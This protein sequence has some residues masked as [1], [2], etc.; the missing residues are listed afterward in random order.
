MRHWAGVL[1]TAIMCSLI[2]HDGARAQSLPS[3]AC[4]GASAPVERVICSD[5][6][7][8]E[9]DH[10]M[11]IAYFSLLNRLQNEQHDVL[12]A[13]QRN[14]LEF[15]VEECGLSK[16][17]DV[18]VD[19][20]LRARSC[21][22]RLYNDRIASLLSDIP[23]SV[24]SFKC[25]QS[26]APIEQII[27]SDDEI[28]ELD[29]RM[30]SLYSALES[31]LQGEQ[32]AALL[33]E[34]R[35]W[36]DSR[37]TQCGVPASGTIAVEAAFH[38]RDCLIGTYK[39]RIEKLETTDHPLSVDV[40]NDRPT[41]ITAQSAYFTVVAS[42][43][44][45]VAA[46]RQL[47]H[48]M[49]QYPFERFS[50]YPPYTNT[51]S[52]LVVV[53][54]Y[55]DET[56]ANDARNEVRKLGIA[57]NPVVW[58]IPAPFQ[59][60]DGWT[61]Q[62]IQN[63]VLDCLAS[64]A[65][66][67]EAM[68]GCSG[69]VLTPALLQTCIKD[70]AC[71]LDLDPVAAADVLQSQ[72]LT[73]SSPLTIDPSQALP[74]P[75]TLN[76]L[77]TCMTA[78]PDDEAG[79]TACAQNV[80]IGSLPVASCGAKSGDGKAFANCVLQAAGIAV[81]QLDCLVKG[82]G[83]RS[84]CLNVAKLPQ[85]TAA[86][87]CLS[88]YK[89][90][91]VDAINACVPGGIDPTVATFVKCL[92]GAKGAVPDTL[93]C[94]DGLPG[95]VHDAVPLVRCLSNSQTGAAAL[96]ACADTAGVHLDPAVTQCLSQSGSDP[97]QWKSCIPNLPAPASCFT[98]FNGDNQSILTCLAKDNPT[99]SQ[100]LATIRCLTS[101]NDTSDVIAGCAAGLIK[102]SKTRQIV[103]CAVNA[104]GDLGQ[105]TGCAVAPAVGGEAGRLLTCASRS[106]SYA[107][108]A[109]CAA[110]PKM[111]QEWM[112]AAQC[113]AS[114]GGVPAT[115]AACTAGWL[116]VNEIGKC[117]TKGIGGEGCFGTNNTIVKAFGDAWHDV[118]KG[119]GPNND[120]V[121][122]LNNA[123]KAVIA[124]EQKPLGGRNAAIPK[125]ARDFDNARVKAGKWILKHLL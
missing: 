120:A 49:T 103:S 23:Y 69:A 100:A 3:F 29:A 76:A 70:G 58:K 40:L 13:Q 59:V 67:I 60:P 101:G 124:F 98:Q 7:L 53:A 1:I 38:S 71:E 57:K 91:P 122:A 64:G 86:Q 87:N 105:L 123:S 73:W 95:P 109:L 55:T 16:T 96:L 12:V 107:G 18:T 110:G 2:L 34:Q 104:N 72:N 97:T 51:K 14:W 24:P 85:W 65:Q 99:A 41:S 114:S 74:D 52:W 45:A 89:D 30:A 21:L 4:S 63:V 42:F 62:T 36:L 81:P 68:Y 84:A 79:F 25:Q 17:K 15:R 33:T 119:P 39:T 117:F 56:H 66:T 106:D 22:V 43:P 26:K 80:V 94:A 35:N 8:S 111:N 27:C 5:D 10:L 93:D 78:H 46:Q 47:Q 108:F 82:K 90:D 88:K 77:R 32:R 113:A 28:A 20:A 37:L 54:S 48:L 19:V 61:P 83:D 102:D 125:A 112:I 92:A 11:A 121:K 9:L 44:S 6:E 118:T 50:V 115:A 116:T 31:R 75:N